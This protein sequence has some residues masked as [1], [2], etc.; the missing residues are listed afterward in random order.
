MLKIDFPRVPLTSDAA[1][2]RSLCEFGGRLVSLHLLESPEARQ[3][4]TRYPVA[5]DNRIEKDYPAYTPPKG[6]QPG[7][8][9]INAAQYFEGMP[10][11]VWEFYIGGYQP[12]QKWL[13]D[14][15]GR[16]L[17]YDDLSRYQQIV[18]ALHNSGELVQRIDALIPEWPVD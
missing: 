9:K 7:R 18:A 1:L 6:E 2:F 14:R 12:A 15:R 13:K 17:S 10:P 3:F 11:E 8:V 4:I 16:Q 5:G